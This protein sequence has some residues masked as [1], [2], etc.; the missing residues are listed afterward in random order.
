MTDG[1]ENI[2]TPKRWS[3]R[4]KMEVVLRL[5]QGESLDAVS[6]DIGIEVFRLNEWRDEAL[7]GMESAFKQRANDH[8]DVEL[9]RAKKQIG[10]LS[11]EVELLREKSRKQ[12]PLVLGRSRQ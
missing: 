7:S 11:M 10:E 6:R 3:A 1:S 2:V 9:S 5:F 12:G 8:R 4:R